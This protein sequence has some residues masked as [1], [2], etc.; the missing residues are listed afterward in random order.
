MLIAGC[1]RYLQQSFFSGDIER[2]SVDFGKDAYEERNFERFQALPPETF[3][4][5]PLA[6]TQCGYTGES[7]EL[8]S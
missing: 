3:L 7:L 4:K 5:C 2:L 6:F 8:C 1:G